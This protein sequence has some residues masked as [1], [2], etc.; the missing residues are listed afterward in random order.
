MWERVG[1]QRRQGFSEQVPSGGE[2]GKQGG[3]DGWEV[4]PRVLE[5]ATSKSQI[6]GVPRWKVTEPEGR[7]ELLELKRHECRACQTWDVGAARQRGK[8]RLDYVVEEHGYPRGADI[9]RN[10]RGI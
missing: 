9:P 3:S 1:N 4:E 5:V 2:N 6:R 10:G 7:L 8:Q